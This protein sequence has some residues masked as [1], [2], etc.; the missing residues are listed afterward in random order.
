[1]LEHLRNSEFDQALTIL[2]QAP[3]VAVTAAPALHAALRLTLAVRAGAQPIDTGI[4]WPVT[5]GTGHRWWDVLGSAVKGDRAASAELVAVAGG[6]N[7]VAATLLAAGWTGPAC[8]LTNWTAAAKA[9]TPVWVQFGLLQ[10]R[11]QV[12]GPA[13]ALAWA[14]T[15]PAVPE[16]DLVRAELQLAGG[17][18]KQAVATLQL[19]AV[20]PDDIGYAAGWTL[21]TW[22]LE[23]G[24][25]S[26]AETTVTRAPRLRDVPLGIELLARCALAG[27]R[28]AE[29]QK[30][31]TSIQQESLAAGAYLARQAYIR[32]DWAEARRITAYWLSRLPDNLELRANLEA[33]AAAERAGGGA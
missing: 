26:E 16:T 18:V 24:L 4:A 9:D 31:Y 30:L 27:G 13:A 12:Q 25:T 7:V 5:R 15:L 33:I 17:R 1:V 21:A 2:R 28:P 11:R 8:A 20:R 19:L 6:P 29:A 14:E 32:H 22:Q 10:A 3:V 23:Q